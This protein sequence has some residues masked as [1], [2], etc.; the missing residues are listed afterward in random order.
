LNQVS[1][2]DLGGTGVDTLDHLGK[3][4]YD[5]NSKLLPGFVLFEVQGT[6]P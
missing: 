6:G 3:L 1:P 5:F 2:F 4:A